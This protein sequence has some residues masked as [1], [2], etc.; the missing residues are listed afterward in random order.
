MSGRVIWIT[1]LSG[2]GKTTVAGELCQRLS[3]IGPCPLLLDGDNLREIFSA[4]DEVTTSYSR[5]NRIKLSYKYGLLCKDLS[6]QGFT[7]VIA[8]VSMFSE[9]YAWNRSNLPNYFEIFL[10]V[11][12]NELRRRDPKKIYERFFS[13]EISNVAG[14]D[15]KIDQP[16][17][18][19]LVVD[20]QAGRT[21]DKIID[22][23]H[24]KL[25]LKEIL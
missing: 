9:I 11:P 13:G 21:V 24:K 8:T 2:S 7:V 5:E 18:A 14:L 3:K 4:K 16:E 25:R 6:S 1:G 20:F 23:I 10:D 22:I 12:I 15:L 19:H 17:K